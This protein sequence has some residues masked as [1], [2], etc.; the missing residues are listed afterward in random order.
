[1]KYYHSI[2]PSPATARF[3]IAEKGLDVE[4]VTLDLMQGENRQPAHLGRNPLGQLPVL[5]LDD[6][7][8]VTESIAICETLEELVPNPPLIGTT[9]RERAET[10][11]WTQRVNLGIAYP[12]LKA[13]Q[14]GAGR[15]VYGPRTYTNPETVAGLT[16]LAFHHLE[17]L[18]REISD[19]FLC[20]E[21]F[22][23]ADI[24][25][26]SFL[27]FADSHGNPIDKKLERVWSWVERVEARPTMKRL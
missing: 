19:Q 5:E 17:W 3:F 10:R 8:L 15:S 26:F 9:L 13:F 11:M 4:V 20:G 12:L 16:G 2:G 6:G 21:R 24:L 1:M 25:L 27:T 14:F 7:T 23:L 18:E 22:T